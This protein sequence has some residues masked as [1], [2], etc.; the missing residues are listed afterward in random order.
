MDIE[1]EQRSEAAAVDRIFVSGY[2]KFPQNITGHE[3]Y[4]D[5]AI[6][7]LIDKQTGKIID[8]DCSLITRTARE[9]AAEILIGRNIR[10]LEPAVADFEN[11]YFG[12]ARGAL[13][14]SLQSA[15]KQYFD[16]TDAG[17]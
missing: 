16:K 12:H 9:F 4:K 7:L 5:V 1:I 15:Q 10:N 17:S 14:A 13:I 8:V 2:A 3:L 11:H 6:G